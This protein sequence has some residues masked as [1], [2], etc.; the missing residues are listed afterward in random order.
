MR[1]GHCDLY[2]VVVVIVVVVA[3]QFRLSRFNY[4]FFLINFCFSVCNLYFSHFF[5]RLLVI[6]PFCYCRLNGLTCECCYCCCCVLFPSF[7]VVFIFDRFGIRVLGN[8]LYSSKSAT[9]KT[10]EKQNKMKSHRIDN[11]V[12]AQI[13]STRVRTSLMCLCLHVCDGQCA[14]HFVDVYERSIEGLGK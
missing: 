13:I 11:R 6:V 7:P 14:A 4:L 5:N 12:Q 8:L 9:L 10:K 3:F 1:T 2:F